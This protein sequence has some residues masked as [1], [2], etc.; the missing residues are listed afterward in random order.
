MGGEGWRGE[1]CRRGC[2]DGVE[3]AAGGVD[4]WMGVCI[5]GWR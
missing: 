2:E 5:C 3:G 4:C 1:V